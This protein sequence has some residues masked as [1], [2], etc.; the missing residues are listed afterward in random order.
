MFEVI[1]VIDQLDNQQTLPMD[2]I[3]SESLSQVS[4]E[5]IKKQ[6]NRIRV[7]ER[8]LLHPKSK[9]IEKLFV[10]K[11][12]GFWKGFKMI[13]N[14]DPGLVKIL[15]RQ[16]RLFQTI[17]YLIKR[18]LGNRLIWAHKTFGDRRG[19]KTDVA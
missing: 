14:V 17:L 3:Q 19:D 11:N 5:K 10:V 9:N 1:E 18:K 8:I 6:L 12:F 4:L 15:R 2:A 7:G 16:S 13:Q